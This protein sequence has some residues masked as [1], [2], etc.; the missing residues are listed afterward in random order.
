MEPMLEEFGDMAASLSFNEPKLPLV[1]NLTGEL[2]TKEQAT[3]PA[4]WVRHVRE[5]VRFADGVATLERQNTSTYLELGPDPVLCAMA[6]ECLADEEEVAFVPSRREGRDEAA[7]ISPAIAHA[8]VAGAKV[9][10]GAFFEG[11]G[12]KRVPLPTYPFQR[13]RYWLADLS[14]GDGGDAIEQGLLEVEWTKLPLAPQDAAPPEV[15][16]HHYESESGLSRADAAR[17]AARDTLAAIQEWLGE[18]ANSETRLAFVTAAALATADEA[19][20]PAA[21][22]IWGLVRTAISEHP[23]RFALID[24]DRSEAS[25]EALAAALALGAA[26]PEIALRDGEALVPRLAR[27]GENRGEAVA[28]IDPERTVLITGGTGGLSGL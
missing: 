9:D 4:Y 26:E 11:T 19:P 8:H 16:L 15:E 6:R 28:A 17:K 5:P 24:I 2:L 21:A 1:S 14:G 3:D 27:V 25:E 18:E 20:D 12:A 10:W 23:G 7:A 13:Q 22:G